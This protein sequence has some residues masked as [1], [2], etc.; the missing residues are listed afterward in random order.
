MIALTHMRWPNDCLLAEGVAEIDLILGGHDHDYQIRKI[1]NKVCVKSGTDFRQFSKID[2]TFIDSEE[3]EIECQEMNVNSYDFKEDP[4]LKHELTKYSVIVES[5]M[6][7][8]LC[9]IGCDLDGR[10]GSIRNRFVE[11]ITLL[12][13]YLTL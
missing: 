4:T 3:Y 13:Q 12:G 9:K 8:I 2:I 1:N 10:F 11:N 5:K 6:D 7:I